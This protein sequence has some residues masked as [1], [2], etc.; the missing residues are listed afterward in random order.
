VKTVSDKVLRH[1]LACTCKNDW[2]GTSKR[3]FCAKVNHPLHRGSDVIPLEIRRMPYLYRIDD[4]A[5]CHL[6]Q[7]PKLSNVTAV[8]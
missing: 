3:K 7:F 1:S 5:G 4:N 2:W 6:Q 8:F